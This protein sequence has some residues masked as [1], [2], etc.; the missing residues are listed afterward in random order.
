MS[1]AVAIKTRWLAAGLDALVP[2]GLWQE[3][4]PTGAT[5]P[6]QTFMIIG[7]TYLGRTTNTTRRK[8]S[9]E[10][11]TYHKPSDGEDPV[12]ILS[13]I[14]DA[15]EDAFDDQVLTID[16]LSSMVVKQND[17][18]TFEEDFQVYRGLNEF[19]VNI[20]KSR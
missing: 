7:Q 2:G 15:T 9:F 14:C 12:E 8:V 18:R 5:F 10:I 4:A 17:R 1:L 16:D 13:A 6:F 20:Q 19:D 3:I 11:H